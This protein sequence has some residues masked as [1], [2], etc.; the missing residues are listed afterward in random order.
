M[1]AGLGR[2]KQHFLAT[3]PP[4]HTGNSMDSD[5]W[6]W[7]GRVYAGLF[8]GRMSAADVRRR[9]R[10]LQQLPRHDVDKYFLSPFWENREGMCVGCVQ[11]G[12]S[13]HI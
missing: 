6:D 13:I 2:P 11:S 7:D 9:M 1:V 3:R 5:G 12:S 4:L 8:L 10:L